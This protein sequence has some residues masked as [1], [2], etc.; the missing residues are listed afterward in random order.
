MACPR[1]SAPG[2]PGLVS[3]D[4]L[5]RGWGP[6]RRHRGH[7][8][9]AAGCGGRP[10]GLWR[11]SGQRRNGRRAGNPLHGARQAAGTQT[12]LGD[13][14][15]HPPRGPPGC[16]PHRLRPVWRTV[17]ALVFWIALDRDVP[18][19]D[20]AESRVSGHC[21]KA[22]GSASQK[23]YVMQHRE[24]IERF[25]QGHGHSTRQFEMRT[26]EVLRDERKTPAGRPLVWPSDLKTN[27]GHS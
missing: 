4:R 3:R 12:V 21:P 26:S 22:T 18:D 24:T 23:F 27:P 11:R 1:S 25:G 9:R 8:L 13:P 14:R 5:P 17:L 10:G 16:G 2:A 7:R 20:L 19:R 6:A 15:L